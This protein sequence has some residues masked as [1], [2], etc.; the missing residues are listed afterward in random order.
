LPS[1]FVVLFVSAFDAYLILMLN[2]FESAKVD[3]DEKQ[4]VKQQKRSVQSLGAAYKSKKAGGDV[5]KKG[6]KF[7]PY[8]YV[9]LDGKSY[10]KKNRR[11][12]VDKMATIVRGGGKRK[13]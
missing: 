6:Q 10:T 11:G 8:A 1:H 5:M 9:P 13:R 4:K 2:K 12:A 7:Q 3:R